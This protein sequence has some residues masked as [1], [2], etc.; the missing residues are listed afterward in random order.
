MTLQMTLFSIL[1]QNSMITPALVRF[2]V[3]WWQRNTN[4]K[5][6]VLFARLRKYCDL[7]PEAQI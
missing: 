5:G 4:G 3:T 6:F 7:A 2:I 1:R